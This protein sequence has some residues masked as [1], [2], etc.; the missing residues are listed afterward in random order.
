MTNQPVQEDQKSPLALA[1]PTVHVKSGWITGL[2]LASLGMW[3]ASLTPIQVILP[4]Q[5]QNID[6][7]H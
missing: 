3:M 2:S 7:A 6:S 1:E 4:L 5:L